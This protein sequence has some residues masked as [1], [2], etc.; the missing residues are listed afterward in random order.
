MLLVH[1]YHTNIPSGTLDERE[2]QRS[3]NVWWTV[4]I[5]ERQ[6]TVLMGV[7]LGISDDEISTPLPAYP[8]SPHKSTTMTMH[9]R[10]SQAF[11]QVMDSMNTEPSYATRFKILI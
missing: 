5:L 4:F 9:V 10:L 1:G 6:F 8:D 2:T 7:P 3:R 11:G